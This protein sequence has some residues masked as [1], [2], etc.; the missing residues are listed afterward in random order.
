MNSHIKKAKKKTHD[1]IKTEKEISW[2]LSSAAE[3]KGDP[4]N[5]SVVIEE[6]DKKE[7]KKLSDIEE[8][9]VSLNEKYLR[10][11]AEYDN[12]RKRSA[13]ELEMLSQTV[14]GVLMNEILPILDTLDLATEHK[15]NKK[16]YEEYIKGIASIEEQ[17]RNV[18]KKVGLKH[19]EV[20]G[21]PFDPYYHDAKV[22]IETDEYKPGIVVSEIKKGYMIGDKV[23]RHSEVI[24]S[25]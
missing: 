24:V 21:K 3:K 9:L 12:Y 17:L 2:D 8:K 6:I 16:T 23:I 22:H 10:L 7:I 14:I 25:K 1:D 4:E 20:V 13:R 19:I 18:L 15:D 11:L 5:D